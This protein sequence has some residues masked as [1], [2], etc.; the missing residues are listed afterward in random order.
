MPSVSSRFPV[1]TVPSGLVLVS[2]DSPG[3]EPVVCPLG[4]IVDKQGPPV[5]G[6][7]SASG[8]S[9][10]HDHASKLHFGVA[11][12]NPTRRSALEE[13]ENLNVTKPGGLM[14]LRRYEWYCAT[15]SYSAFESCRVPGY[16][17][18]GSPRARES[19]GSVL[20]H[21][22]SAVPILPPNRYQRQG[23]RT[24]GWSSLVWT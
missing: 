20:R 18:A 17:Y 23:W 9:G 2:R 22:C 21:R 13:F 5:L 10:F 16:P 3:G 6:S 1:D 14:T 19:C 15:P 11:C 7:S 4:N 8:L 12:L 24:N